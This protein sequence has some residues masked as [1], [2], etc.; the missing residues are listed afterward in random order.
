MTL[1]GANPNP[2][3][4][5]FLAQ[6]LDMN[7]KPNGIRESQVFQQLPWRTETARTLDASHLPDEIAVHHIF[8]FSIFYDFLTFLCI[9]KAFR[10]AVLDHER[11]GSD[12]EK[13]CLRFVPEDQIETNTLADL[14]TH[15]TRP[16]R[17]RICSPIL[18][19]LLLDTVSWQY[20]GPSNGDGSSIT[21]WPL[22][23]MNHLVSCSSVIINV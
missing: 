21:K 9:R 23:R 16:Q 12:L 18:Q 10:T 20:G 2:N 1:D 11:K 17:S 7:P 22:P 4:T 3:S 5:P 15:Y 13:Y 8:L 6:T 19:Y 14:F